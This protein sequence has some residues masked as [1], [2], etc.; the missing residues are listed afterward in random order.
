VPLATI[1]CF[2]LQKY[3]FHA[4]LQQLGEAAWRMHGIDG[5]FGQCICSHELAH[6]HYFDSAFAFNQ[7]GFCSQLINSISGV[8]EVTM[9]S[10]LR[11]SAARSGI[12]I[13]NIEAAA[14]VSRG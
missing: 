3:L 7:H 5:N 8:E 4:L 12:L 14:A 1:E 10:I 9:N 11:T 13:T 2:V 6:R